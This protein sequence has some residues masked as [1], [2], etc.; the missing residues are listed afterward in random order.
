MGIFYNPLPETNPFQIIDEE[1]L[2]CRV[3][4]KVYQRIE[5]MT[6]KPPQDRGLFYFRCGNGDKYCEGKKI[7]CKHPL[8]QIMI[9]KE[10]R[11]RGALDEF[12]Q[13]IHGSFVHYFQEFKNY[14]ILLYRKL[15][16]FKFNDYIENLN[17]DEFEIV[18]Y[19][20]AYENGKKYFIE[21]MKNIGAVFDSNQIDQQF[22]IEYEK[23]KI[24]LEHLGF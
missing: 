24:K 21:W 22:E 12:P 6:N 9:T 18:S 15:F 3:C 16:G 23:T 14:F 2:R 1:D 13:R 19:N 11:K 5:Y 4:G 8:Q 10:L 17:L 20:K 7:F